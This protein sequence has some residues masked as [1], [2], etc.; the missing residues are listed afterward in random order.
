MLVEVHDHGSHI[1]LAEGIYRYAPLLQPA[2][3]LGYRIW[4]LKPSQ[5]IGSPA[6]FLREHQIAG[7]GLLYQGFVDQHASVIDPLVHVVIIPF[8]IR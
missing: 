7:D 1:F 8:E 5:F 4:V 2:L 3:K 6:H